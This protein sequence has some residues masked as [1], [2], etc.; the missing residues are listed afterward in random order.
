MNAVCIL[1]SGLVQGVGYRYFVLRAARRLGIVGYVKNL[2]DGDVEIMAEGESG[3]LNE[4]IEEIKIG[5]LSS[6]VR[7]FKIEWR[8]PSGSFDAFDVRF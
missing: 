1:I 8:E 6:D 7:D 2:Y 3:P 5:P 4:L